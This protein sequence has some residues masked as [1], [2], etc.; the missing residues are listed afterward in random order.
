M[1]MDYNSAP[2]QNDGFSPIPHGTFLKVRQ[3]IRPGAYT[4]PAQ[5]WHDGTPTQPERTGAIYINCE[6]TVECGEFHK[7]KFFGLIGLWSAKGKTWGDMGRAAIRAMLDSARGVHP[8]DNTPQAVSARCINDFGDLDGL[9]FAVQ[10]AVEKDDRGDQ[11][12]VIKQ[13]I[14]P[15]H[16]QYQAV[17]ACA[18]QASAATPAAPAPSMATPRTQQASKP[19]W[20]Q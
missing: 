6:Y 2:R 8:D 1:S 7:R 20:A 5:G 9:E 12:N 11:R 14:E 4:D 19:V 18:S 3:T 17:M 15:G 16:P 10:I 13:I